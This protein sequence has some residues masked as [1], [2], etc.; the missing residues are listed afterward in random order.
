MGN[1]PAQPFL[2]FK[3]E[4]EFLI[5]IDSDGCVF[6]TMEIKQKECFIPTTIKIWELQAV[7]RYVREAQEFVNLYSQWRGSN[8][9]P[10]LLQTFTLAGEREEVLKRGFTM[11]DMESLRR[12]IESADSLGLPTLEKEVEKTGDPILAKVLFWSKEVN[13]VVAEMVKGIP[14]F[15]FVRESLAKISSCADCVVV[16][17]TPGEALLREWKEHGL[18]K[19]IKVIAG[20]E[21]G[22][23]KEHL[24]LAKGGRYADDHVL[25]I[26]DALGDLKA[27]K[28][29]NVLFYPINPEDEAAS[30]QRFYEEALD[31]F[32]SRRYAG[33]YEEKLVAEFEKRL[34][35]VPPWEKQ[36]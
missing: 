5:G 6:D 18:A 3:R 1:N 8:R 27:A 23:K 17:A 11:P 20:Q 31:R 30:W 29:N 16:S 13:K 34:P 22:D 25:M 26:G 21:M 24:R 33:S 28:A 14:P 10:A 15:P 35:S 36:H 4:K 2:D 9:F 19:H 12:W 32:I 7:S